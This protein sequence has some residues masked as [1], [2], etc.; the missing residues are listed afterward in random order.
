[1]YIYV[2][3]ERERYVQE[4]MRNRTEGAEPNRTEPCNSGTGRNRT[5]NRT[6]PDR[7]GP[8]HGVSEKRKPNRVEPGKIHVRTE[9]N[10]TN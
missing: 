4:G 3:R 6:E 7:D 8:S 10:R 9:T 1:M 5:R 2:Y